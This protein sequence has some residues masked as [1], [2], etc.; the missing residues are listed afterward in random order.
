MPVL[1]SQEHEDTRLIYYLTNMGN[2]LCMNAWACLFAR[3][4]LLADQTAPP[5]KHLH[6]FNY[7]V[8]FSCLKKAN[9]VEIWTVD[10]ETTLTTC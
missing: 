7:P 2:Y 3:W 6:A 8:F 9:M 4:Q 5:F 10:V 1:G